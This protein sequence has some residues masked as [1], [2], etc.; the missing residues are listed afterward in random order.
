MHAAADLDSVHTVDRECS[1]ALGSVEYAGTG[2]DL[3][4]LYKRLTRL[5]WGRIVGGT[6]RRMPDA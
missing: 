6:R 1:L 4:A 3:R 5:E 2:N